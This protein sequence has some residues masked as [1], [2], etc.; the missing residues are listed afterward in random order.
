MAASG[1][2]LLKEVDEGSQKWKIRTRIA[3]LWE[4]CDEN[5]NGELVR[6]HMVLVDEK[7]DGIHAY[8]PKPQIPKFQPLLKEGHVYY[9]QHFETSLVT[10]PNPTRKTSDQPRHLI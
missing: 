6:L 7:G 3:R 9:F 5:K 4:H 10:R 1:Y 8:V 2:S